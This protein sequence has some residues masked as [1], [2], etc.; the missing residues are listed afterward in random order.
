MKR[1]FFIDKLLVQVHLIIEIILWTGLAPWEFELPF[2]GS[3]KSAFLVG[4]VDLLQEVLRGADFVGLDQDN[5]ACDCSGFRDNFF[6][7][8]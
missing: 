2:P 6:A 1:E 7:Q 3:L 5:F 4:C 8:M